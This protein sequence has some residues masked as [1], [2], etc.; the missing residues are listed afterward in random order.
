MCFFMIVC[1]SGIFG[2]YIYIVK[3]MDFIVLNARLAL[4]NVFRGVLFNEIT[5]SILFSFLLFPL[6]L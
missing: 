5:H 2:I 1:L 3:I 6:M 4:G